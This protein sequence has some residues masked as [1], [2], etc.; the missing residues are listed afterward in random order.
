MHD[1]VTNLI[2]VTIGFEN[3]DIKFFG[4]WVEFQNSD[5]NIS[6]CT[7]YVSIEWDFNLLLPNQPDDIPQTHT[8][9]V[10]IGNHL[11]PNE[12]IHIFF[13]GGE[14]YELDEIQAQM[15]C[16]IDFVNAQICNELKSVVTEWYDALHVNKEDQKLIQLVLNHKVKIQN[17]VVLS[18]VSAG[19]IFVNYLYF[20]IT[21]SSTNLLP[22]DSYDRMFLSLTS[23][24]VFILMFYQTGVLY[25][26][27]LLRKK[28]QNL[29]RY[30]IFK[31]TKG[32]RNKFDV[33]KK[34]NRKQL[35]GLLKTILIGISVNGLTAL[36]G[37]LTSKIAI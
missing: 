21:N 18:F 27:R 22:A 2:N 3:N 4:N 1:Q 15:S 32:D 26:K 8:L 17:L 35:I 31:F 33:I 37:Y 10:R 6:P 9:R 7:K 12:V 36:I 5:W 23:A 20:I 13:Q 11:K 24:S 28:I 34:S 30:S 29:K 14:E 19:I 25:S 16:K